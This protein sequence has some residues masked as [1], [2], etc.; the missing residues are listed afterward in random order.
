MTTTAGFGAIVGQEAPIRLLKTFLRS[1]TQPHALLF[2]G[3]DGVGKKMTAKAFAMACNCRTLSADL[4]QRPPL[5]AI[6]ACGECGPCRKIAADHHPDIIRI[7]PL[8][9]VIRIDQIRELLQ[10][11]SLKPNEAQRR[12]VIFCD[13]QTMNPE[14]GNALLKVLEEPPDRTLLVLTTREAS[15]LLPTVVSR[16]RQ[17]RFSPL[18]VSA[19]ARLLTTTAAI[20]P[21]TAEKA[22]ALCGGS[23]TRALTL[24]D[25]RWQ[26]RHEWIITAMCRFAA[27]PST[28]IRAWLAF[29]EKLAAQKERVEELLE[30]ITMWLRDLLVVG[31]DANQVLNQDRREILSTVAQGVSRTRLIE[32][33]DAVDEAKAALRANSKARLTLDAW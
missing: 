11:L 30:I 4:P 1:G 3:D 32:Q 8:S 22:A 26:Q 13:A 20:D 31:V 6:D 14:A 10:T 15:D 7:A 19:V 25:R 17:I 12:V 21:Q 28:D 33:I 9:T 18:S 5:T 23:Y 29:S 2:T 16:C 27:L 24:I